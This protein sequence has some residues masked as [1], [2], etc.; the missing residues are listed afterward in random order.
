MQKGYNMHAIINM[1]LKTAIMSPKIRLIYREVVS[2]CFK[3]SKCLLFVDLRKTSVTLCYEG[4]LYRLKKPFMMM[5][6]SKRIKNQ[7]FG[8]PS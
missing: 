4:Q 8:D 7:M 1:Q 6:P 3:L 5:P 2:I